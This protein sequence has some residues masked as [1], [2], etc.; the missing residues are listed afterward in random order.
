MGQVV[1]LVTSV[2]RHLLQLAVL[3]VL[4]LA[5]YASLGRQ[6]VPLVAEYQEE[7]QA[8]ASAA[9]Q[10]PVR[11]ERLEGQWRGLSPHL[12]AHDV[13]LG[14]GDDALRLERLRVIVD[15][16]Q[17]L[18]QRRAV[19][20]AVEI[21]GPSLGLVEQPDGR[22]QVRGLPLREGEATDPA[23]LIAALQR[24]PRLTLYNGQLTI[25]PQDAEPRTLTYV[26]LQLASAGPLMRLDGRGLLPDGQPIAL[27]LLARVEAERWQDASV[28]AYL[29][30]P[31]SQWAEW[32]PA[33]LAQPWRVEQMKAGGEA[34]LHWQTGA[35]Q[36]AVLRLH[37][38]QLTLG[39]A[40]QAPVT[41]GDVGLTAYLDRHAEGYRLLLDNL[42][43]EHEGVRWGEARLVANQEQTGW[44]LWADRLE[45]GPLVPLVEALAPLSPLAREWLHGLA[46]SGTLRN[47]DL[48]YRPAVV[49]AERLSYAFNLSGVRFA[50]HGWVPAADNVAGAM[51]GDLAAGELRLDAPDSALHLARLFP[52]GWRMRS[53]RGRLRWTVDDESFSLI[54][55]YLQVQSEVGELAGDFLIRLRRAPQAEDYMDLRVGLRQGDARLAGQ[56]LPSRSP[57]LSPALNEWLGEAIRGGLVEQGYFLY[58]G[59][60]AADAPAHARHLG[61]YFQVREAELDYRAGWPALRDGRGEILVENGHTRVRLAEGRVLNSQVQEASAEIAAPKAGQAPRLQLNGRLAGPLQ[62]G[63]Q[64][65][66]ESP[67]GLAEMFDGWQVEG[68]ANTTL[69]L[70][71]P[72]HADQRPRVQV[73]FT[74]QGALLDIPSPALRLERLEGRFRYDSEAG[75]SGQAIRTRLF[76]EWVSARVVATG[77][78]RRP[79]S[80]IEAR[81]AV[82]LKRLQRWLAL[83]QPLPASG[84]LPYQLQLTL[85]GADSQLRIESAL[86]GV[87]LDLPEPFGKDAGSRRQASLHMTL[88]GAERRYRADYAEL[89][90]LALAAPP[91]EWRSGRGELRL[92][93]GSARL[94]TQPGLVVRGRLPQLD[95]AAWRAW[96]P[97]AGAGA[98]AAGRGALAPP[99]F[100]REAQLSIDH[101]TGFGLSVDDLQATL[102]QDA[103][104]W[105]LGVASE[106][107]RGELTRGPRADDIL[108]LHL[109]SVRLPAA[110]VGEPASAEDPWAEIDPA[111]L[112]ALNVQID[113]LWRGEERF[114][115]LAARLRPLADSARITD[116]NAQLRG[117]QLSG[118]MTWGASRTRYQGNLAGRDIGEV[119]VAWGFA[120]SAASERFALA[121]DGSWPGSPAHFSFTRLSGRLEPS[122]RNGRFIEVDGGAQALRVFGLLNFDSI[123]RRLRL[124]FSDLLDRGL[125]YDR[126]RGVLAADAGVYRTETPLVL[127]GPSSNLE[128][129]GTLDL[130]ADRIDAKLLVTLPVTNNLPLAAILAGAPAIAGALWVAD[131][132]LGDRMA[133]FATVQYDV[134]GPWQ[135]PEISFDR[136]FEKPH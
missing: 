135:S 114:G 128:L 39:Q 34:W 29:N 12:L 115:A 102:R 80:R 74:T 119:L 70:E 99:T 104:G 57:A 84:R 64:L 95:L 67:L 72:L 21:E 73:D 10:M 134:R 75:F 117:I 26:D 112:P 96:L 107:V 89:A 38:P 40:E 25:E 36:R 108:T 62:D 14:E 20:Y 58:Q 110:P 78:P 1:G 69:S 13:L 11:I 41:L 15:V 51:Q 44:H 109:A 65:L 91:G 126:V 118:T 125:S 94:P 116:I 121:V 23:G 5:L 136:P 97:G 132:V 61:L 131:R 55:P 27:N 60:L 113:E 28:R 46:P 18:W 9:L 47:V 76:N 19:V 3:G 43:F 31:Q 127:S 86:E 82:E 130:A 6:L 8:R 50:D 37:A 17:S 133:R 35:L 4:L 105:R 88:Q 106:R 2:L 92:G 81:G 93:G 120:R 66:R 100:L 45:L 32:L 48:H 16:G 54:A 123:G 53:A 63:L 87:A 52:E 122:L 30:L 85:D 7:V 56:F 59:A 111:R 129:N 71:I 103:A 79:A 90:S 49:G 83:P 124:D 24:L 68:T 33:R 42:A 22:W 77:T 101:F 98:P